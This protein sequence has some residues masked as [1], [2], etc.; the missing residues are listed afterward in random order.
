MQKERGSTRLKT[1]KR[2]FENLKLLLHDYG[3]YPFTRQLAC[4]LARRGHT[5]DYVYSTSTQLIQR[6]GCGSIEKN[7]NI[8][9][10][11]LSQPFEKYN[12][13]QRRKSEIEHG[14]KLAALIERVHPEIV[15]SANTPLDA[16]DLA[17]RSSHNID[18][19]FIFWLQ[20]AIGLAARQNLSKRFTI[21]GKLVGD[22]Y[23]N[24]EKKLVSESDHVVLISDDFKP[25]MKQWQVDDKRL[26]TINNWAPVEEIE[27]C[28]KRNKWSKANGLSEFFCFVYTGILGLKHNPG[29]FVSL[30]EAFKSYPDVRIVVIS[31]GEAA[32]WLVEQQKTKGLSN[33]IVLQSQPAEVYAQVLGAGDVLMA[34][35]SEDAGA[36][37]VPSKVLSYLCAARPLLLA[38]PENNL[39]ARIV[40]QSKSGLVCGS[41]DS[42]QWIKNAQRLYQDK[43]LASEMASNARKYAEDHF[44]IDG[45]ADQFEQLF[46]N[47]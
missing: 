38:V 1:G 35:L 18:A 36:Y 16:Q 10:I 47:C 43:P 17:L 23:I 8:T 19:K 34:I 3:N 9:G 40:T 39:S 12:Y 13:L 4:E 30:A 28:P 45:I 33:L 25:L 37:S 42:E 21:A 7:L 15:I 26:S 6:S 41:I 31:E 24:H 22:Y 29:L 27:V 5:V 46:T 11:E 32:R 44:R 20:D 14:R 2:C